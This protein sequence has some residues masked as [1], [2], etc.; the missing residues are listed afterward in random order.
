MRFIILL[1]TLCLA[2]AYPSDD[3][4][5]A[6][7]GASNEVVADG[8]PEEEMPGSVEV[9]T[10]KDSKGLSND[11]EKNPEVGDQ[12]EKKETDGDHCKE[13]TTNL[14]TKTGHVLD[15]KTCGY[16]AC[17]I[18]PDGSSYEVYRH[19]CPD[20]TCYVEENDRCEWKSNLMLEISE[21]AQ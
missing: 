18:G 19:L 10:E 5:D 1:A 13:P 7:S 16:V 20:H 12:G 2:A 6:S 11:K 8:N 15:P 17:S 3:N 14:C 9:G 4:S 21:K